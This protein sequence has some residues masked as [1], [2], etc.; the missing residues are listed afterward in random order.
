[1]KTVASLSDAEDEDDYSFEQYI[2]DN[3]RYVSFMA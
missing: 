3:R 1:M 2:E